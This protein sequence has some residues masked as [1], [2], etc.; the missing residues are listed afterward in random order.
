[1]DMC[2]QIEM[3]KI[4]PI[5]N[6]CYDW[7]INY[8]PKHNSSDGFKDKIM[9]LFRTNTPKQ[10]ICGKGNKLSKP[11]PK[12]IR[13]K[14]RK[15][16]EYNAGLIRDIRILFEQQQKEDYYKPI[17]TNSA[18]DGKYIEYKSNGDKD[19]TLLLKNYL[20]VIRPYLND[21]IN[22]RKTQGEWK[23]Q[24]IMAINFLSSKDSDETHIMHTKSRN[25]GILICDEANNIT[26]KLFE[27]LLRRYQEGLENKTRGSNFICDYVV[28]LYY[29]F[30]RISLN[31]G[32]SYIGSPKWLRNKKATIN[33]KNDDNCFQ[34]VVT[35]ALNHQ[36]INNNPERITRIKP[37]TGQYNWKDIEF[38]SHMNDW[39]KFSSNSKSA[40][41][42]LYIP[43]NTKEIRPACKSKH[44]SN[45]KDQVI[46]LGITDDEKWHY[47]V[48]KKLS[49]LLKGI[50]S[51]N[52]GYFYCLN[53][54]HSF[55][56]KNKLK[57]HENVR[58][59]HDY[60]YIEMPNENNKILKYNYGEK[61]M[62]TPFVF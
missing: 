21:L 22:N 16:K 6:T 27:S 38:P 23:V 2:E 8:I 53:C 57:K 20:E 25:I 56:T 29:K 59:D 55:R 15:N 14:L 19:K 58:K 60:C 36:S 50:T 18:F 62:K 11:K 1:M 7:L 52:S 5:K 24:L 33:P 13:K 17:R 40:F 45:R 31:R 61:S 35:V 10:I 3:N 47:L 32:G 30:H 51:N 49:V 34:Y 42:I 12:N 37:F 28:I 41:N 26:N 43:H 4:R 46:L 44:N 48:V 39:K 54:F 9:C